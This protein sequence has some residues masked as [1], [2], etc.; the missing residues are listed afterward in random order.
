MYVHTL[1]MIDS[2]FCNY[3]LLLKIYAKSKMEKYKTIF[4]VK[5]HVILKQFSLAV[6]FS[7][8]FGGN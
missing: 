5:K 1:S 4:V 2:Y 6:Y 7:F 3:I 8:Y